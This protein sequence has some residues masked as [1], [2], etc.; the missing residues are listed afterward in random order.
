MTPAHSDQPTAPDRH[1]LDATLPWMHESTTRLLEVLGTLDDL[2]LLEPSTL[3]GWSRAHVLGHLARN[4]DA[5]SRLA[6]W[7]CT[8]IET[9]MYASPQQ[10][11]TEID[12]T[13]ALPPAALR[14]DLASSAETLEAGLDALSTTDWRATVRSAKGRHIP[15]AEI[16][17]MRTREVWLHAIDLDAEARLAD[18]PAG[19][20]DVLLDD[21]TTTLS[22]KPD[23]PPVR[24]VP[25]DRE[26]TWSLGPQE[27]HQAEVSAPAAHLV[28]WLTG[29]LP[30]TQLHHSAPELPAWL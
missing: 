29:R 23:C 8:G 14:S 15:A 6:S 26:R 12:H 5:L 19:L 21:V 17:W 13:A 2:A 20:V 3:P 18:L 28:G 10:R 9:P 22:A 16:P 27:P 30:G 11:A 25:T 24:L 1:D 7:A 4:A